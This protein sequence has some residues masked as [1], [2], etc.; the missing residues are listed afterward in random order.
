MTV[1]EGTEREAPRGLLPRTVS[2]VVRLALVL[3]A[4][5]VVLLWAIGP[6]LPVPGSMPAAGPWLAAGFVLLA[7]VGELAYVRVRH[8]TTTEDLTFFEAVLVAGAITLPPLHAIGAALLGLLLASMAQRRDW[9]KTLFNLG[10][11]AVSTSALIVIFRM[12]NAGHDWFSLRS[13]L[14]LVT[15]TLVFALLNVALL[16]LVLH[17]VTGVDPREF[18]TDEW[19]LSGFMAVGGVGVGMVAVILA[20]QAP[21]LLPFAALPALALWYAYGAAAQHAEARERNRWLVTLG[22]ALAQQGRGTSLLEDACEAVRQVVGAPE[23]RI[24]LPSPPDTALQAWEREALAA[25]RDV[26]GPRAM[27]PDELPPGWRTGV[28]T[29]LDVGGAASGA[30]LLGS[31]TRYRRSRIGRTRGWSLEEADAPVLG[32]LV[33]AVGSATRAGV[34]FDALVEE[35]AKLSAV[36][37]N[38]SDGIAVVDESGHVRLWSQTMARMTGVE[39]AELAALPNISHAPEIV[40]ELVRASWNTE[41]R[42]SGTPAP[43]QVHLVRADGEQLDVSVATVRVRESSASS[44]TP[45]WVSI[46]TVHDETRERRVERMKTDFVA[47]ISHELRT[48]ITPIKGYAHLL[49]TRGDRV[50][51]E[52]R[53]Q[54]LQT[55]SDRAD[56]LSRL[57]DDLLMASRVSDGTRLAVEMGVEDVSDVVGQAVASFPALADRIRT[58]LPEAPVPVQCDRVRAVQCLSNLL[59]NA[60]KYTPGDA[61]IDV[62]VDVDPMQVHIHVRDHGPGIPPDQRDKVFQR[63]YRMEDPF[64]MRTGGAGLGL[65]IA[66][67]LA[68]AMGGGLTLQ[69]PTDGPGALFVLHLPTAEAPPVGPGRPSAAARP[70]PPAPPDTPRAPR[71]GAPGSTDGGG[72]MGP[73]GDQPFTAATAQ[74]AVKE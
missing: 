44:D 68:I 20:Q 10:S 38:T 60:E 4:A 50:P 2:Q 9:P 12:L 62:R 57:V 37:D 48:P 59:G 54:A 56:H 13:V 47:T 11:Y 65:H 8:G 69:A 52:K 36:V 40:Q 35:T 17:V 41:D 26:P 73:S 63:F 29:R 66:R 24:V 42:A 58:D 61:P 18:L 51:P 22:G 15:A 14:A 6:M 5:S 1:A 49:A 28:A 74:P 71:P 34:T 25:V 72:S 3:G 39:A 45:T 33:A 32:A 31:T 30:L 67:E 19:R 23:S 7:A 55:I 21:A 43:V 64:T 70:S 53:Q 27:E 46:L 16:S